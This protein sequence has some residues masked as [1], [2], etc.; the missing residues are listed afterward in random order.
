VAPLFEPLL[1]GSL[2]VRNRI[3]HPA[4]VG[5]L[6]T[7]GM[8]T[9]AQVAYYEARARGGAGLIVTEGMS[10]HPSSQPNPTIVHV[11]DP[12]SRAGLSRLAAAVRRHGAAALMQLW[13]VGRQQLWGPTVTPWGISEL[14]DAL[15]GGVPHV[16][17]AAEIEE[18]VDSFIRSAV[19][20]QD[21]GFDGVEVHGAHGY[22]VTQA[23]SPWSNT[24]TDEYGGSLD[25][26]MR[27]I[28]RIL[29]GVREAC[30]PE[31][32]CALKLSGSEFVRGGLTPE[33]TAEIVALLGAESLVDLVAIGQGNFSVSLEKHVPDMRFPQ[34]PFLDMIREIR[35]VS[36]VPVMAI[37]RFIDPE[38]AAEAV[39]S[40]AA[41]LVGMGRA[42][43]SDPDAPEKWAGRD[44]E[45]VRRCISCNE[46]WNSIHSGRQI[47]CIHREDVVAPVPT[48]QAGPLR[49]R[50][51]VVGGGPAGMEAAWVAASRG[52]DVTLFE[53][54][55]VL[56]GAVRRLAEGPGL[57]E[58]AG[59]LEYQEDQLARFGVR[60]ELGAR[61]QRGDLEGQSTSIVVA[62]GSKP[63]P[64]PESLTGLPV[65]TPQDDAWPT[66]LEAEPSTVVLFD[67][68]GSYYAY[69]P[70]MQ[71]ATS[72]WRVT[73]VTS[74]LALGD[75]LGHLARIGLQR[76]LRAHNVE[77]LTGRMIR[78]VADDL[79]LEDCLSTRLTT[80]ARPAAAVW[81]GPRQAVDEVWRSH[82]TGPGDGTLV[83]DAL[84]PRGIRAAIH[85]G[86]RVGVSI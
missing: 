59:L 49:R 61:I 22:L 68:D 10:V 84:S 38:V 53:E 1:V 27:L 19:T 69:G 29:R 85:E 36:T 35:H 52:H 3:A 43:I 16:M 9:D 40:E 56:G 47:T 50:V 34:A 60:V 65:W 58:F 37:G 11:Y 71:L 81:A 45:P 14:P 66:L 41:D 39:R 26:R 15:S 17:T 48:Y 30:G 62:T 13:H 80:L 55:S 8:V 57:H 72:G 83:G 33:D 12:E 75:G 70:L 67:E 18:V 76:T 46:C 23:L 64:P 21:C 31:F 79:V 7:R 51:A 63:Q 44:H 25:G 77:V 24:R 73:L 4:I 28:R 6:G 5:N 32:V 74:R 78:E 2:E 82:G 20:A 42:L 86:H 54:R